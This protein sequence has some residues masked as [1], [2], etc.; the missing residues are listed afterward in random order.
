MNS[1]LTFDYPAALSRAEAR[2]RELTQALALA[3]STRKLIEQFPEHLCEGLLVLDQAGIIRL[4]N[5][6]FFTLLELGDDT[7]AWLGQSVR[8]LAAYVQPLV[9]GP[10]L[11][12]WLAR[13]PFRLKQAHHEILTL[14]NGAILSCSV[15]PMV[16]DSD[17]DEGWLLSLRDVSE[18]Q[19]LLAALTSVSCI[20]DQ[21]PSP[22]VRIGTN[23]RQ[24]YANAAAR[25][26]GRRLPRAEQV[27]VQHQLRAGAAAALAR[28]T[29]HQVEVAMG[30]WVFN[31][32][33]MPFPQEGYV[34]LYFADITERETVRHQLRE[35]QDFMQQV[36]DTIPNIVFVRDAEQRQIFENQT[37]RA[38]M[39]AAPAY[40]IGA[41]ADSAAG[42]ELAQFASIDAQVLATGQE[43][44][45]IDSITQAD[46]TK[47]WF[48]TIKRP[49]HRTDGTV[50][51]LAVS[52]DITAL[53]LANQT[54]ERSEKQYRDLMTY[55]QALIFT[56]DL[57][58]RVLTVNPALAHLLNRTPQELL[59]Q[60]LALNL[61]AKDMPAYTLYLSHMATTP[62]G[63]GLQRILPHGSDQLRYLHFRSFRVE[64][65]GQETYIIAH[66]HDITD[67]ILAARELKRAKLEAEA[68]VQARE[69]F[70]SNMSHEIRTPMNGVLGVAGLL[71]KTHLTGEQQEYLRII[72]NSGQ[73]LLVVLNDVL[74]M[75]KITSGKLTLDHT[76]FDLR[77]SVQLAVQ[78]LALQALQ[79]GLGFQVQ[80]P[81]LE[82][83]WVLSDPFRLNQVLLN[84]L[85]NA[86]KF[87]DQGNILLTGQ[88]LDETATTL[89]IEFRVTDTGVGMPPE[90]LSRI[91]ESFTQAYANTSRHFG[92]TGLGLSISR[93]LVGQLGGQLTVESTPDVGSSFMFTLLLTKADTAAAAAM[94][95]DVDTGALRGVQVLVVED[96][97]INRFVV[98]RT[99]QQWGIVVTEAVSGFEGVQ[100]ADQQQF[101]IV[102]MDIQ[103]PGMNGLEATALIR[104][105]PDPARANVPLLALTAN[106]FRS[107]HD[108]Y[109]AAG[110]NDCLAKPFEEAELYV[111]LVSLLNS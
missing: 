34:N 99:M 23:K 52:T 55:S 67:R 35:Q 111:R 61:P 30:E 11:V 37:M 109:R 75:A 73:H 26:L 27:R 29:A 92:G 65:P 102:L 58:G 10:V 83:P 88:V 57:R 20:P 64:E 80:F 98:R 16:V 12:Q 81:G 2:I 48:R 22:I 28:G 96:N 105:H 101:D 41:P 1:S 62:E 59:G 38:V 90:V 87:T 44:A 107:D 89:T 78:P 21:N 63:S 31:I 32:S 39:A 91:F 36:L 76:A 60:D 4:I 3:S 47:R 50:Q 104:Q 97:A 24:L 54:L 25:Q 110:M 95:E 42:R 68:A 33:V 70:L 6:R 49:L 8:S 72:R 7:S 45:T 17:S 43:V 18:Q 82:V 79:K 14:N 5:Q 9:A 74:D 77:D 85:S 53:R 69:N 51:V 86:L 66:A 13:E 103:M 71:A 56:H 108:R 15:V 94:P 106:A 100:L 93:A 19:R 40:Q 46:G 84:L